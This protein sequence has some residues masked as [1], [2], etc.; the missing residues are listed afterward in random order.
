MPAWLNLPNALTLLRLL[1][2]P[3][4]IQAILSGHH[5]Q[6]FAL[7]FF[8]AVTDILDGAAARALHLSTQT[9]AY[10]DPIADKT[11]LSGVFIALAAARM[12][13]WW[14]VALVFGRDIYILLGVTLFFLFTPI[15]KF[16]PSPWGKA[17][18]FFQISTAVLWMA[19]NMLGFSSIQ[20]LAVVTLWLSA[21]VTVASGLHYTWRGMQLARAH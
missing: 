9:G 21:A 13:P 14:F 3:F 12:V 16:P 19:S 15:R 17:S 1:L 10:L 7:F 2:T 8:A 4:I 6:A 11:L 5:T 20:T 18:T